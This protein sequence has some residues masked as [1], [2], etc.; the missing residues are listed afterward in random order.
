MKVPVD[1]EFLK[2]SPDT[3]LNAL[4]SVP[5]A[6]FEFPFN[7]ISTTSTCLNALELSPCDRLMDRSNNMT[8]ESIT[9]VGNP[10]C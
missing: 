10:K 7:V 6:R 4:S 5:D 2:Y 3:H 8:C 9:G 1:Q